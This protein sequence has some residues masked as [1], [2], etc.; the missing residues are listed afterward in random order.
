MKFKLSPK[1]KSKITLEE[2]TKE[3]LIN[4]PKEEFKKLMEEVNKIKEEKLCQD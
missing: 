4:L 1:P 2:Q 3:Y